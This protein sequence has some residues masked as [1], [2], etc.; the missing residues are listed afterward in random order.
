M[1][2][3]KQSVNSQTI[4][5]IGKPCID[6]LSVV[7]KLPK[8]DSGTGIL[9][10][11]RQGGGNVATAMVAA[12]RLG[13]KA[14]FIGLSGECLNGK[15]IR[16]DFEYNNV[17]ISRSVTVEGAHSDFAIV[18]S[19]LETKSRS[20]IYRRGNLRS[21]EVSDLD[22]DYLTSADFLHL[23]GG[24]GEV[25]KTASVWMREAGK[26]V[27]IDA[28]GYSERLK[29]FLPHIDIFIA[30]EFYYKG[31]FGTDD[32]YEKNC[33]IISDAGPETVVFTL[34][35]KGCVGY[36]KN[37]G[38][39]VEEGLKVNVVDTVGAGDVFHGA[40][41]FGLTKGWK[42][43]DIAKFSNA[44][45]AIKIGFIGGRAGIPSFEIVDKFM[46]TGEI[47]DTEL[48]QRAEYYKNKWIFG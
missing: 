48:K 9:D 14:G 6:I 33:K 24:C 15:A 43:R 42:L 5:G 1:K 23:E 30:S 18:L 3:E 27:A 35:A 16:E 40:F 45:S 17:D 41:L 7:E 32:N 8:P 4:V 39:F 38:F 20:I 37:E 29:N 2:S 13:A 47:D 28:A 44:V 22:K 25:E 10:F 11:S 26:K 21:L 36:S 12:A 46:K 31:D 34:G 19:D